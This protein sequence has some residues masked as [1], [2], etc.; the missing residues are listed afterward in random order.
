MATFFVASHREYRPII[1][2]SVK[3]QLVLP[4]IVT[5]DGVLVRLVEYMFLHERKSRSW[6]DATIFALQ[7]L[8]EFIDTNKFFFDKPQALFVAFSNSMFAGTINAGSDSSGLFWQPR[9]HEDAS[10]LI[11]LI[12]GFTDWLSLVNEDSRLQLNPWHDSN[13]HEQRLNWAAYTHHKYKSLLCHVF[14]G[15]HSVDKSRAIHSRSLPVDNLAPSKAFPEE[16]LD[17]LLVEGFRRRGQDGGG[18]RLINIRN[19]LITMLMHYGGL[20]LSEA[21]SIWSEDVSIE[22]GEI[23]VRV[24][25]PENGIAPSGKGNRANY[26][27]EKYG[28]QP[29]NRLVKA[30]DPLFLGWK[31]PLI[32]DWP[33]KCLDVIF[34][35]SSAG[36]LFV[37]LW[38]EYHFK[39]RAKPALNAGHPYAF[40]T[41]NGQPYSHRMFRKAHKLAVERINEKYGKNFGTTPHG[42]RHAYGQR[43]AESGVSDIYIKVAMHH[44]SIDSSRVYTEPTLSKVRESIVN[45]ESQLS[46]KY[47]CSLFFQT[48]EG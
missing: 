18:R 7:L 23:Y 15:K 45:F 43:M 24:Y 5:E 17:L 35:P 3:R 48:H 42:H 41:Q 29:R 16:S 6:Q 28:L 21:L 34:F 33:R 30:V 36:L 47:E 4:V 46:K 27:Y 39:E 19:I 26:L 1:A 9:Q 44:E 12:T 32:T 13:R 25:H 40:T 20:R 2:G 31:N 14:R 8:I 22:D 37:Q 11:G 38:R 10:K